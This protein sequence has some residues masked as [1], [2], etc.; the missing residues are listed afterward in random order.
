MRDITL[1]N[2]KFM[3]I[4]L[5]VIGH[6]IEPVID[7]FGWL[8]SVYVFIYI[9]HMPMFAYVS[10]VVSSN[11][12]DNL[13]IRKIV[14]K[15]IIPYVLLEIVYSIFDFYAFS[16]SSLNITPLVPYWILWY[17]FSLILWRL[18]LPIISEFRFPIILS[19]IAGLACGITSY[20]DTLSFSRTFVFFPFFLLGHFYHSLIM[21]KMQKYKASRVVG[22]SIIVVMFLVLLF[23]P[24]TNFL[25][26]GWLYGSVSYSS[27]GVGWEQGVLYRFLTYLLAILLG[28]AFLSVTKKDRNIGTAY[29]EHSLYIY[30]LHGF[31]MKGLLVAGFY[32]YID[33]GWKAVILILMS[34]LLLPIL[35]SRISKFIADILMNPLGFTN[36]VLANKTMQSNARSSRR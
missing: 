32:R 17:L 1:D 25:N 21:G 19:I 6:A 24:Q 5:I 13:A 28:I 34:L 9:F 20:G 29:G 12:I 33:S 7:K 8:K 30:V 35:S 4:G 22:S 26:V 36:V 10:G 14:S 31:V 23:L 16:R 18:L 11:K 27:L 3:L 2:F 15:L